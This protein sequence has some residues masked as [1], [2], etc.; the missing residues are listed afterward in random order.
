[1]QEHL[2]SKW[3]CRENNRTYRAA[4]T[5][6]SDS[7]YLPLIGQKQLNTACYTFR[8]ANPGRFK[9]SSLIIEV[10]TEMSVDFPV[11]IP[12]LRDSPMLILKVK[13]LENTKTLPGLIDRQ[14]TLSR[15]HLC[16]CSKK[17]SKALEDGSWVEAM[18]EELLQFKLQQS[19]I[20]T[21]LLD[22][23]DPD[24]P[25]KVYKVV[26]ALYDWHQALELGMLLLSHF[27]REA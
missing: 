20:L 1:M 22:F 16:S 12:R 6:L 3:G 18:Q 11:Q 13:S 7:H 26:K 8:Q 23:V 27:P 25:T 2:R 19:V 24:H 9:G 21:N 15:N 17:V 4:R 10:Q 5:S 14:K